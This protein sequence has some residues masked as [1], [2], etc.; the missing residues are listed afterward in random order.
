M[1]LSRDVFDL[2]SVHHRLELEIHD[3]GV[4]NV[5]QLLLVTEDRK[6]WLVVYAQEECFK[7]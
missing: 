5:Y 7:S 2:E 4:W 3:P 6:Q 1:F